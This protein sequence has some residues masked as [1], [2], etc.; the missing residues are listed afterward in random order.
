MKPSRILARAAGLVGA[1]DAPAR[2][3]SR[4]LYWR[5][6]HPFCGLATDPYAWTRLLLHGWAAALVVRIARRLGLHAPAALVAVLSE[7]IAVHIF[8]KVGVPVS[9]SQALVGGVIGVGVMRGTRSIDAEVLKNIVLGWMLTPVGAGA[10]AWLVA[11][12]VA[13]M[14]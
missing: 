5:L 13:R 1:A 10:L 7:A 8:A 9:T 2:I 4:D 6:L 3:I 11:H 14:S 12:A